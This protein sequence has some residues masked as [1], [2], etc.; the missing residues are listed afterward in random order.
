MEIELPALQ[1]CGHLV[2]GLVHAP[3]VDALKCDALENDVFGEV[4]RDGFV[5]QAKEGDASAAPHDV[6]GCSYR[7]WVA[8]HFEHY[9]H[10]Q[11][12]G[13]LGNDLPYILLRRI[14]REVSLHFFCELAPV[15]VDLD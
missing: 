14:E 7:I 13:L 8:C 3:A 11:A 12:A 15:L 2:P 6:E 10:S 9:V 5:G 1:Q 4:D